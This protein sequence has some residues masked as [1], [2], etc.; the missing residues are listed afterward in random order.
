[1]YLNGW[2]MV[3]YYTAEPVLVASYSED[4]NKEGR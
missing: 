3:R 2:D 4:E 1:M